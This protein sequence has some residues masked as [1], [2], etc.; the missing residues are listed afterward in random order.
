MFRFGPRAALLAAAFAAPAIA[1]DHHAKTVVIYGTPAVVVPTTTTTVVH[2]KHH[3]HGTV[4]LNA[5][6]PVLVVHHGFGAVVPYGT[7]LVHPG[8]GA[9]MPGYGVSYPGYGS[10][11]GYGY[12]NYSG[13]GA[14]PPDAS[15]GYGSGYGYGAGYGVGGDSP[16]AFA[17][18]YGAGSGATA[19]GAEL[20][21]LGKNPRYRQVD[22]YMASMG[23][24]DMSRVHGLRELFRKELA[25]LGD[26]NKGL[27]SRTNI[28]SLL[29]TA[30][31]DFLAPYG[32]GWVVDAFKPALQELIGDVAAEQQPAKKADPVVGPAAG[33][34]ITINPGAPGTVQL[35]GPGPY[36]LTVTISDGAVTIGSGPKKTGDDPGPGHDPRDVAPDVPA[37]DR[38]AAKPN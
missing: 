3:G 8:Y 15:Y 11:P 27:L 9:V 18:V 2:A 26:A 19:Y 6:Q 1:N 35:A 21:A 13:Y 30:A 34:T 31:R 14:T 37:D 17:G 4:F 33:P 20:D 22:A 7:P 29:L 12:S 32:L 16:P 24:R 28:E 10:P 5:A 38:G 25:K 23:G 36:Q